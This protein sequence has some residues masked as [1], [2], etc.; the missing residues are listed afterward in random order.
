MGDSSISRGRN[1][2]GFQR[3]KALVS[4][5]LPSAPRHL[6]RQRITELIE[7]SLSKTLS[8]DSHEATL[9]RN[10][11]G[12]RDIT[13]SDVMVP[14]ADIFYLDHKEDLDT[15][16]G[17]ISE[18]NHSRVPVVDGSLD[19][20][21]GILHIKDF[22]RY[23]QKMNTTNPT[24]PTGTTSKGKAGLASMTGAS[25][26]KADLTSL[27]RQPIFISPTMRL[28]DLLDEMR[29]RR[30]HLALV[31][32]EFGGTDGLI[33]IEDLVEEIIG[34]INDEHDDDTP[35]VF[36]MGE[37]GVAMADARLPIDAFEKATGVV[38]RDKRDEIDTLGGLVV[39]LAGRVPGRGE[40]IRHKS[41]LEFEIL[42]SDPR[43]VSMVRVCG[44]KIR[45]KAK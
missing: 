42:D 13:A 45:K 1:L 26:T 22:V 35:P 5:V 37:D 34:E 15:L 4:G 40:I 44:I 21:K 33:T 7:E 29:I 32:D 18:A 10:M 11:L 8:F 12:L 9:L 23:L 39:S 41:G 38:I 6:G 19:K 24:S 3:L 31:V 28:L 2:G 30:L 20:V 16:W 14:R 27:L 25:Q 17:R 43:H 36:D